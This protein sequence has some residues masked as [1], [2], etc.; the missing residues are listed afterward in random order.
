[1]WLKKLS[2]RRCSRVFPDPCQRLHTIQRAN[3]WWLK[4]GSWTL[5]AP[6]CSWTLLMSS[7]L[8]TLSSPL[9]P[10][11]GTYKRLLFSSIISSEMIPWALCVVCTSVSV[12]KRQYWHSNYKFKFT[13]R[14][15]FVTGY[16]TLVRECAL[17]SA[18]RWVLLSNAHTVIFIAFTCF[19]HLFVFIDIWNKQLAK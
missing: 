6:Q 11:R 16:K 8:I 13:F 4:R 7:A 2:S 18:C 9:A 17:T 10:E 3:I 1:M 12:C 5:N 19:Y 15:R 14:H